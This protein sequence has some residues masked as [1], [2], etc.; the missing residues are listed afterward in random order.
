VRPR[1]PTE[2]ASYHPRK[3]GVNEARGS[4][5]RRSLNVTFREA[6]ALTPDREE[7]C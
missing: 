2:G 7:G 1:F 5:L 6:L 3:W 4:L